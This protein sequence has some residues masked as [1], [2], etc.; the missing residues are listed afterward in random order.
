MAVM[1]KM[2][3]KLLESA[4]RLHAKGRTVTQIAEALGVS[5]GTI[6][7]WMRARP[8]LFGGRP[9]GTR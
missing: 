4:A 8:D 9:G 3:E 6:S 2:T 1:R 7:Y 5:R